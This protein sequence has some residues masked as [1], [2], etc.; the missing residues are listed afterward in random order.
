MENPP[1]ETKPRKV[2]YTEAQRKLMQKLN[3]NWVC[4]GRNG[5]I[6]VDKDFSNPSADCFF[7]NTSTMGALIRRNVINVERFETKPYSSQ[8]TLT[9]AG[10]LL[11]GVWAKKGPVNVKAKR[12]RRSKQAE[13]LPGVQQG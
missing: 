6:T 12:V 2:T 13:P 3:D 8:Y 10:R 7:V 5:K 4:R 1:K 9:E 11:V